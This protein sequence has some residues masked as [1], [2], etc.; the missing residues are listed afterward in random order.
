MYTFGVTTYTTTATTTCDYDSYYDYNCNQYYD[1]EWSYHC[2]DNC[3]NVYDCDWW[4]EIAVTAVPH[5]CL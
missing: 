3:V 1:Y 4:T 5:E 2:D